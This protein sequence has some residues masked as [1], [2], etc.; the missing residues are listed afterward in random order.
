MNSPPPPTSSQDWF[1]RMIELMQDSLKELQA[2]TQSNSAEVGGVRLE[3][4]KVDG[5]LQAQSERIEA[6]YQRLGEIRDLEKF[7]V[8]KELER[9]KSRQDSNK[10]IWLA[11]ISA[12]SSAI[13]S[14]F[15]LL[16]QGIIPKHTDHPSNTSPPISSTP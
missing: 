4:Q 8:D 13:L 15:T 1:G 9:D 10:T 5:K 7:R 16:S 6:V 14:L 12:V 11:V 3:I 2:A